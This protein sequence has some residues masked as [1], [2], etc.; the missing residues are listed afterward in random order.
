[1]RSDHAAVAFIADN[2]G[3]RGRRQADG[4]RSTHFMGRPQH[5][6]VG[7]PAEGAGT[8]ESS[9]GAPINNGIPVWKAMRSR[10]CLA[11]G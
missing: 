11:A 5:G 8:G 6:Q 3:P 1:M 7:M 9:A 4:T 2:G 10:F